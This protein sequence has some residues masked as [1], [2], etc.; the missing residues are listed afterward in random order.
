MTH[1]SIAEL[2]IGHSN[3]LL[4]IFLQANTM[5]TLRALPYAPA[6][7]RSQAAL[8]ESNLTGG[9]IWHRHQLPNGINQGGYISVVPGY[10]AFKLSKLFR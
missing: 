7:A 6:A 9:L 1:N 5:S 8:F 4:I 3:A 2:H 10:F